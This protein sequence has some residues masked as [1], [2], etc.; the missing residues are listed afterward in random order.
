[1][2]YSSSPPVIGIKIRFLEYALLRE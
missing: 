1:M 2:T